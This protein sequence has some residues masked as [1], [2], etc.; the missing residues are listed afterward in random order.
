MRGSRSNR[1]NPIV[2]LTGSAAPVTRGSAG[3]E[4][5]RHARHHRRKGTPH[6]HQTWNSR[7]GRSPQWS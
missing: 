4:G 6:H 7:R 2:A 1:A 5:A 3:A